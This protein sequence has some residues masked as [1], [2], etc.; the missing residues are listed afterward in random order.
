MLKDRSEA[1]EKAASLLNQRTR[2]VELARGGVTVGASMGLA[3]QRPHEPQDPIRLL[4]SADQAVC[5][6][7]RQ[8]KGGV[9]VARPGL[10]SVTS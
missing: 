5:E 7:K 8:G 10:E 1:E 4:A 2:P 3:W 6:A 9:V